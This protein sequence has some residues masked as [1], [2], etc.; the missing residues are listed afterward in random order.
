MKASKRR[1]APLIPRSARSAR[2]ARSGERLGLV[3]LAAG[4]AI[5]AAPA[6]AANPGPVVAAERAFA[7]DGAANGVKASFLRAMAP[8]AIVF[9]PDP[10]NA[11]AFYSR[12][13]DGKGAH[14]LTWRP[15]Y[16]GLAETRDLG[17]TTGPY[18]VDGQ[19]GGYYFTVWAKQRDGSWKWIFDGGTG[20][21]TS[22]APPPEAPVE[23]MEEARELPNSRRE[24]MAAVRKAEGRLARAAKVDLSQAYTEALSRDARVQGSPAA[25]ATDAEA[26]ARELA[27]R[28]K[29]VSFSRQGARV[30]DIGD[31]VFTYGEAR[32]TEAG[33]RRRGHYVRIWRDDRQ[34]FH[35]VFDEFIPVPESAK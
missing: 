21:D 30:S 19:P 5:L 29:A 28:P 33:R 27:T 3:T 1:A 34:A 12:R 26:I 9:A 35:I 20:S 17:F 22:T 2:S 8:D 4:L 6:Q 13:P 16:A 18:A 10:V 15:T 31:L 11:R 7:A 23:A 14:V 24:A 25:P 32:W